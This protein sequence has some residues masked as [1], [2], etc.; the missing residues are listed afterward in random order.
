MGNTFLY[1]QNVRF[2]DAHKHTE[3]PVK[4][5]DISLLQMRERGFY[6]GD[7]RGREQDAQNVRRRARGRQERD[8]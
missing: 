8:L 1:I 2:R 5:H 7:R 3:C 4:L 6:P